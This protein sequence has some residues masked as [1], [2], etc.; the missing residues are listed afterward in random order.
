MEI[1]HLPKRSP[2][3]TAARGGA[4]YISEAGLYSLILRSKMPHAQ[5]F[6]RWVTTE[7]LP[8]IRKTGTYTQTEYGALQALNDQLQQKLL[9]LETDKDNIDASEFLRRKGLAPPVVRRVAPEFGKACKLAWDGGEVTRREQEFRYGNTNDVRMY[10]AH[11]DAP[12]LE[13]VWRIFQRRE[14]YQRAC[15]EHEATLSSTHQRVE[16][17]LEG[18]RGMRT[19][20]RPNPLL[21]P[22]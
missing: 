4:V 17:R 1:L 12:F 22:V 20:P 2:S 11:Q 8:S 16:E 18:T 19:R 15:A 5:A 3:Q 14:L 7:V 6:K 13:A 9:A 10:R 21:T